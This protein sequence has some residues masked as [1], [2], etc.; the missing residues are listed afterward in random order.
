M[1]VSGSG[2]EANSFFEVLSGKITGHREEEEV[3]VPESVV[4]SYESL[5]FP[6]KTFCFSVSSPVPEA[7]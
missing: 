3:F 7:A 6:V 1:K 5:Y 2:K 4:G